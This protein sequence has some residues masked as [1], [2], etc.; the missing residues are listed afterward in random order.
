MPVV[1]RNDCR[2]VDPQL[3]L[4]DAAVFRHDLCADRHL[5]SLNGAVMQTLQI[6]FPQNTL[7][8][9]LS[10]VRVVLHRLAAKVALLISAFDAIH[11]VASRFLDEGSLALVAITYQR[12]RSRLFDRPPR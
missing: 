6:L 5:G 8:R 9:L 2:Q 1:L 3:S 12:F 11:P 10:K 7:E 4:L